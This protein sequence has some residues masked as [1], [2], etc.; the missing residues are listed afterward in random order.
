MEQSVLDPASVYNNKNLNTQSVT[1]QELPKY[2]AEQN[3]TYQIGS[4]KK[5]MNKKNFFQSKLLSRQDFVLSTYQA[6]NFQNRDNVILSSSQIRRRW[7]WMT[8]KLNFLVSDFAR[9]L[10]QKTQPFYI[11]TLLYFTLLAYLQLLFRIKKPKS[12]IEKAGSLSKYE[13]VHR[14]YKQGLLFFGQCAI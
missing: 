8:Y 14:L 13:K 10:R 7:F 12:K 5:E 3:P 6:L 1:K 2:Q 11:F 4:L 9:K